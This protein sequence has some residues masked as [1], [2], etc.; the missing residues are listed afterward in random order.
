MD[1]LDKLPAFLLAMTLHMTHA[2]LSTGAG[3][4][5]SDPATKQPLLFADDADTVQARQLP[6][7]EGSDNRL[8]LHDVGDI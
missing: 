3:R 2:G 7:L 1:S 4:T 8:G 5:M 6:A